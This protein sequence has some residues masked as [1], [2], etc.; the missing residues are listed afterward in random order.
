MTQLVGQKSE[1]QLVFE[2][3]INAMNQVV[4]SNVAQLVAIGEYFTLTLA[5]SNLLASSRAQEMGLSTTADAVSLARKL[6]QQAATP[7]EVP[8]VDPRQGV[9]PFVL[10]H[11]ED[12]EE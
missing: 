5:A 2:A 6:L 8:E 4:T 10:P 3:H 12:P 11:A 1:T 7:V 9:L